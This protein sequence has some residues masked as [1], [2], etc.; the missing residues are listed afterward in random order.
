MNFLQCPGGTRQLIPRLSC[1][2][3]FEG[4]CYRVA[5][6]PV[7]CHQD[8]LEAFYLGQR[9]D[10][11]D[12]DETSLL[13]RE[14]S[15]LECLCLLA[16]RVRFDKLFDNSPKARPNVPVSGHLDGL[17]LS[18]MR[19][20][21]MEWSANSGGLAFLNNQRGPPLFSGFGLEKS[22]IEANR[23]AAARV[24]WSS[25][26]AARRFFLP[27][28]TGCQ[29]AGCRIPCLPLLP[30]AGG[31][32]RLP[33]PS[34]GQQCIQSL[35]SSLLDKRA[36]I[37]DGQSRWSSPLASSGP[38][39]NDLSSAGTFCP[40][41]NAGTSY[42]PRRRQEVRCH[43]WSYSFVLNSVTCCRRQPETRAFA[44]FLSALVLLLR[45]SHWH[46]CLAG[47]EQS[48]MDAGG[49]M[50]WWGPVLLAE[51]HLVGFSSRLHS[52]SSDLSA[53]G[54]A[55]RRL[56]KR[57]EENRGTR[58]QRQRSR[59]WASWWLAWPCSNGQKPRA[60]ACSAPSWS[61]N[62]QDVIQIDIVTT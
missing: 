49:L 54:G 32:G 10:Q 24:R 21:R 44:H 13:G 11:V 25:F 62:Y 51:K 14:T 42:M 12:V 43:R 5:G 59:T 2:C 29:L 48:G 19:R 57:P 56:A 52:S 28:V 23:S 35:M 17:L 46:Q 37:A 22:G 60:N 41:K 26:W 6:G 7:H 9:S 16:D 20:R 31:K 61:L 55:G 33:W 38:G 53:A 50:S 58:A 40:P 30:L 47:L 34:L 3:G 1:F 39:T 27:N 18:C 8:V 15:W 36:A 4:H 45:V